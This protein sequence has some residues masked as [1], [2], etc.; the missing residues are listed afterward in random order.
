MG[1]AD[2]LNGLSDIINGKRTENTPAAAPIPKIPDQLIGALGVLQV[3]VLGS[4]WA[5]QA[6]S[7][8]GQIPERLSAAPTDI[9][10]LAGAAY[11]WLMP[12]EKTLSTLITGETK[13]RELPGM[14]TAGKISDA[15]H[16]AGSN[17]SD[18]V[19]DEPRNTHLLSGTPPELMSNWAGLAVDATMRAPA[20]IRNNVEEGLKLL[21]AG[22][23]LAARTAEYTAKGLEM[24]TP[25]MVRTPTKA[26]EAGSIGFSGAIGT[27]MELAF[28][29]PDIS[30]AN[31]TVAKATDVAMTG[32]TQADHGTKEAIAVTNPV[33][34]SVLPTTGNQTLDT[35]L[36]YGAGAA[37]IFAGYKT[38]AA[39]R[40]IKAMSKHGDET[41][42]DAADLLRRQVVDKTVPMKEA[43]S[44]VLQSQN[45]PRADELSKA[46]SNKIDEATGAAQDTKMA[47]FFD[48]GEMQGSAIK[49]P[50]PK[51]FY[52]KLSQLAPDKQEAISRA[53]R[54][55]SEYH[56]MDAG[57]QR[58]AAARNADW[59][60][61]TR[62]P[63]IMAAVREYDTITRKL[64]D[65]QLEQRDISPQ[66]HRQMVSDNSLSFPAQLSRAGMDSKSPNFARS[67]QSI[68]GG[69]PIKD[70]PNHIQQVIRRAASNNVQRTLIN[71]FRAAEDA[72]DPVAKGFMGR[73]NMMRVNDPNAQIVYYRDHLGLVRSQEFK[74]PYLFKAMNTHGDMS[75][76]HALAGA[77]PIW[78]G[79]AR[80]LQQGATGMA[81]AA[82][83]Q[84]FAHIAAVYNAMFGAVT[85][86]KGTAAGPV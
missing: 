66:Q 79:M 60:A 6:L 16:T 23:G 43:Y 36:G 26:I 35:V 18:W 5:R 28:P 73:R 80:G 8:L 34:A 55:R 10:G 22:K 7:Q 53:I 52:T 77:S 71:A 45:H 15:I 64:A 4:E 54:S 78:S 20:I 14:E 21:E 51:D 2:M 72:G 69:D 42:L 41:N 86:E 9:Y 56:D 29:E 75:R 48:Y 57:A 85:R 63:E 17:V 40:L 38:G 50:P 13:P 84:P 25:V 3:P 12:E 24:I 33:A 31:D 82:V 30:K 32:G 76:L 46:M 47:S 37:A 44:D 74:D 1:V 49:A 70:L 62:D 83:G 19:L 65:F 11:K 81:A 59:Q 27:G 67:V 61:A 58:G 68:N 39:G